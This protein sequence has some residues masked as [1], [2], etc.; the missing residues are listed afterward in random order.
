MPAHRWER[1]EEEV[2]AA[3]ADSGTVIEAARKLGTRD[4]TL[5]VYCQRHGID[6]EP[7]TRHGMRWRAGQLLNKPPED[8]GERIEQDTA[9]DRLKAERDE[10]RRLYQEAVRR[11]REQDDMVQAIAAAGV[12]PVPPPK[13]PKPEPRSRSKAPA[14]EAILLLSDWHLGQAVRAVDTGGLNTYS[15]ETATRRLRRWLD[16]AVGSIENTRNAYRVDRVVLAMLGDMIEGHDI[17]SGQAYSLDRDAVLQAIDGSELFADAIIEL[18]ERLWP[19]TLDIYA[20]P[21]NHGKPGGRKA[22]NLPP[23]MSFDYAFYRILQI[24]LANAPVHEWGVEAS[25]RL[26]FM[27]AGTPILL[28]HGDEVRGWSG[29]PF[30]GIDKAHG[31]LLQELDTVFHVWLLGH[32]HASAALPAGRG[33]RIANGCAVGAN[34][35]TT[36][37]VLG[38]SAPMQTLL[39]TSPDYPVAELALLYLD[40]EQAAVK[41]RIYGGEAA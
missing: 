30:Y 33:M 13:L 39:Y 35:L 27:A 22:G 7:L 10:Y 5:R 16:A 12:R 11:V 21:G 8:A 17:F 41:P 9:L 14:R 31:R 34:R 32:W 1:P 19:V 38:A 23:T 24:R 40:P 25:G 6:L 4:A 37:A 3:I 36:T 20:V 28:T 26:L 15:W 2:R 29:F 18:A